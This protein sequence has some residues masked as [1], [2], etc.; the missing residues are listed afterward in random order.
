[1][2]YDIWE[3]PAARGAARPRPLRDAAQ[4]GGRGPSCGARRLARLATA[5]QKQQ[6]IKT[7]T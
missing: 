5:W 7:C 3:A 1:M 6:T 4:R 2:I